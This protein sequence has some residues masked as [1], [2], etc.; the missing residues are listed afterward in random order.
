MRRYD[1]LLAL[2][3]A[4][5]RGL[6]LLRAGDLQRAPPRDAA[7]RGALPRRQERAEGDRHGTR[8]VLR[9]LRAARGP[10]RDPRAEIMASTA[11]YTSS[12]SGT[13]SAEP[14]GARSTKRFIRRSNV[15]RGTS[16]LRPHVRQRSPISAPTRTT[17]HVSP[18]QGCGLRIWAT[19]PTLISIGGA[20]IAPPVVSCQ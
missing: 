6:Y 2:R 15:E 18:P 10:G 20:G 3:A 13:C 9:R 11:N 5:A 14:V 12:D 4:R 7:H 1:E 19:S 8:P 17:R 16:T